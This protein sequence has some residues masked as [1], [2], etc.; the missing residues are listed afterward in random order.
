MKKPRKPSPAY[1]AVCPTLGAGSPEIWEKLRAEWPGFPEGRD[2]FLGYTWLSLAVCSGNLAEV[3]WILGLGKGAEV[4]ILERNGYTP[5]HSAIDWEDA[6]S[7]YEIMRLLIEAGAD[8]NTHGFNDWTP[9]HLAAAR[10]DLRALR[11]VCEAGADLSVR[12]RIDWYATPLEELEQLEA[13]QIGSYPECLAYL[14]ER[15]KE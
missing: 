13:A 6:D 8:L 3:A 14:R 9:A 15:A 2:D 4:S 11:I 1:D 12:T 10:N 5:L 7:K